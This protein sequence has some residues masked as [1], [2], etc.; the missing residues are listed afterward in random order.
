MLNIILLVVLCCCS[1][2]LFSSKLYEEYGMFRRLFHDKMNRHVPVDNSS[3]WFFG[4]DGVHSY[5]KF[6][7]QEIKR[8]IHGEWHLVRG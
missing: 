8:D 3:R 4:G 1:L 2:L 7:G 6:C 5:C